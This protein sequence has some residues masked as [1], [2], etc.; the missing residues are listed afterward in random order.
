[1]YAS[2]IPFITM[3]TTISLL[4]FTAP[5]ERKL[6][7]VQFNLYIES[8]RTLKSLFCSVETSTFDLTSQ[9]L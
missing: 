5:T 3:A 2:M 4:P 1:M 7:N 6:W 8:W 9:L